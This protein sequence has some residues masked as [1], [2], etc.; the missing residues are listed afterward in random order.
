M[1]PETHANDELTTLKL[2]IDRI[3]QILG[4]VDEE[5]S[6]AIAQDDL[7]PVRII[8]DQIGQICTQVDDLVAQVHTS[9]ADAFSIT[10]DK[11]NRIRWMQMR[12]KVVK[13]QGDARNARGRLNT[14]LETL[15]ISMG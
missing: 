7:E 8:C 3:Q 15:S 12:S 10:E 5:S 14:S 6:T 4:R 9:S 1:R 2:V 13:A 11:I